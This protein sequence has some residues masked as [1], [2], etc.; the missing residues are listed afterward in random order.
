MSELFWQAICILSAWHGFYPLLCN[1]R[2]GINGGHAVIIRVIIILPTWIVWVG[3]IA[4]RGGDARGTESRTPEEIIR[5]GNPCRDAAK[6]ECKDGA[7]H[8]NYFVP[9]H[10][11]CCCGLVVVESAKKCDGKMK[12]FLSKNEKWV[13]GDGL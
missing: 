8:A 3:A 10:L 9:D 2:R 4:K 7:S 13:M 11:N 1:E 6:Q 5:G 12:Y